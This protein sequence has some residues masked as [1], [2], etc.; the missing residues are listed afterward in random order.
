MPE[1][2]PPPNVPADPLAAA[3]ARWRATVDAELKGASFEKK[4]VTRTFEGIALQPL[5]TRADLAGVPHL[6]AAPGAAPFLRGTRP[7]GY[8]N[9]PWQVAQEIAASSPAEFNTALRH[10]LMSG[11]DAVV[12][13]PDAASRAG[14]DPDEATASDVALRGVS[15]ADLEDM[16][17]ALQGVDLTVV[18]VHVNTGADP[19]PIAALYLEHARASGVAWPKLIGTLSADPLSEWALRG[20][21]GASPDALYD[22]LAA[23]TKW[24]ANHAPALHTVGVDASIWANA[25]GTATQE[26]ALALAAAAEYLRAL[27]RRDLRAE[28]VATRM[29]FRFA[30]G[31][32]FFTEI[33]K[34]RAFRLL[35]TRVV[36][37]F[38]ASAENAGAATV[39]AATSRWDK[40]LLDPHVNMLR[41]TTEALS[42][43]LGGCD[44]LHI[45]P[46]DEV[47]GAT[48]EFSRRIAR[49]VHTLLA[50]EFNFAETADPAGGSW[51]V[52]KL[53]DTLARQAWALFQDIEGRGGFAAALRAGYPQQL[54]AKAAAEK[55][56]A[57]AKRRLGVVG[58]NL[59]PNLKEKPLARSADDRGA[60]QTALADRIRSRRRAATSAAPITEWTTRF[61]AALAAAREGVTVGQLRRFN[62]PAGTGADSAV[63]PLVAC[64]AAEPFETLRAATTAFAARTGARPKVFLA[65]MGPVLQHKAR[66]D[67]SAGF[68]AVGG[69]EPVAKQSFETAEIAAQA[70]VA[71]GAKVAVLCSTDDTYPALVPVFAKAVKAAAPDVMVVLA[72]LPA[73]AAVVESFRAAGVDEFIHVRANVYELL[74]RFLKQIGALA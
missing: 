47:T 7:L 9:R 67:F 26:L 62:P 54:V 68:F 3:L 8:K 41:V 1:L 64:R 13:T 18:P 4:F 19:L 36:T 22:A 59:F 70:A 15:L 29:N 48:T 25:G 69:F 16:T 42:A 72:G 6:D 28:S 43:V 11:Q 66:A 50:E 10:D 30:V 63:T 49:N 53:T 71:S 35:W 58:T 37:A 14:R 33:A 57:I 24:A 46:F 61:N 38:G 40:T 44:S 74:A 45:A 55:A 73:D 31:S 65:K 17:A 5:Y 27:N 20:E 56:D 34:F 39:H 60:V 23:W 32:Q 52:E 2:S 12:L 51:Y 21:P